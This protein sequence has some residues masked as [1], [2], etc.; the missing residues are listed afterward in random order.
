MKIRPVGTEFFHTDRLGNVPFLGAFAI[1]RTLLK[2]EPLQR[3]ERREV[4]FV[5]NIGL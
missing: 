3:N 5:T 1:L 2:M 4:A